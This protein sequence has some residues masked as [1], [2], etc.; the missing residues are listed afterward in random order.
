[1]TRDASGWS[2]STAG[3]TASAARAAAVP[4]SLV[5]VGTTSARR[6][7][8]DDQVQPPRRKSAHL[9]H[10]GRHDAGG[11]SYASGYDEAGNARITASSSAKPIPAECGGLT[12]PFGAIEL[13]QAETLAGRLA[14]D[15][16]RGKVG[17][18]TWRTWLTDAAA[19][20]DA[21]GRWTP[22]WIASRGEPDPLGG[23]SVGPWWGP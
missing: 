10:R 21:E 19:L 1:M 17:E 6:A 4:R 8:Q 23:M 22:E 13:A 16:L 9:P 18:T 15:F 3:P 5:T 14:L 20:A 7:A 11:H 12:S 2:G